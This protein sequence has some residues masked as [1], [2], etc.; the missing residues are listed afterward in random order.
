MRLIGCTMLILS[1]VS[2]VGCGGPATINTVFTFV[3]VT[4]TVT[5]PDGKPL[6]NATLVFVPEE[7]Q[8]AREENAVVND[9]NFSTK[10]GVGK[11]KVTLD[12]DSKVKSSVPS[13][14]RSAKTTDISVEV[15]SS[16]T[17]LTIALK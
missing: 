13:K 11:Y 5:M 15:T 12:T 6:K 7:G 8:T 9:G 14:Y 10:M 3:D 16:N 1:M 2:L 4:G 17:K